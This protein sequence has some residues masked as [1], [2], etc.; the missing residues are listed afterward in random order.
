[1][2]TEKTTPV[3]TDLS[4]SLHPDHLDIIEGLSP[5]TKHLVEPSKNLLGQIYNMLSGLKDYANAV[6]QDPLKNEAAQ[7]ITI[8]EHAIKEQARIAKAFDANLQAITNNVV[9]LEKDLSAPLVSPNN[10]LATEIRAHAASLKGME[11]TSF[12]ASAINSGD[13]ETVRAILGAPHY[14]SKMSP[15]ERDHFLNLYHSKNNPDLQAALKVQIGMRDELIKMSA[16]FEPAIQ[17]QIGFEFSA[18][19]QIKRAADKAGNLMKAALENR[20][21]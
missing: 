17:K 7:T 11:R 12:I 14:L 2:T 15:V 10:Q 18:A 16:S 8:Y 6:R 19:T 20:Q 5:S 9:S 3:N 21:V 13:H 4:L 1:M